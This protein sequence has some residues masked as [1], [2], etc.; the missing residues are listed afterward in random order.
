MLTLS[1]EDFSMKLK[2]FSE[3]EEKRVQEHLEQTNLFAAGIDIGS[4]EHYVAVPESLDEN[5]IRSFSCFTSDLD[6]MADWLVKIGITTV[7]MESTGIYWI[8]V[9]EILEARGLEVILVNAHH[10][11]NVSGR[12]TDVKDCQWIQQL[13]T[14]GLLA[15][16]FR[17]EDNYCVLRAYMRQ[18]EILVS[19]IA[20]HIQHMQKSLRQMNLLLDNVVADITGLTGMLIIRALLSGERDA[21]K[22]AGYRDG[23]C[24]NS[25]EVIAKSLMGNYREEH[26]FTL[27]QSVELYDIYHEKLQDCDI[28]IERCLSQLEKQPPI[29]PLSSKKQRKKNNRNAMNF[30][31]AH[32]LHEL[33]GTDLTE[34]DGLDEQSIL[35]I[36]SETGIDMSKWKTA[37]HFVSW[38]GLSPNNKISGGKILSSKSIKTQNRAKQVFKMAAFTLSNSKSGLGAFY[39]RLRSRLGAPKAINATARKV[40]IIFYNMLKHKTAYKTQSQEEYNE[41]HKNRMVKNLKQKAKQFG[42][43]LVP[44][45]VL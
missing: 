20:T 5:P 1:M 9:F 39:R 44:I 19:T 32:Y 4:H 26:L 28:E 41:A 23:R 10:V 43:E 30:H 11:K 16:A 22:L 18:R 13:H 14:Y 35:K 29:S 6:E 31:V 38:M 34:I 36:L 3:T 8:P 37:K 45:A 24:K 2:N 15:G 17:P 12:K 33:C 27:K 21:E 25:A 7:A 42:L 40:A